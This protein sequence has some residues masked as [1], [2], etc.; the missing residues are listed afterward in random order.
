MKWLTCSPSDISNKP[1]GTVE[2]LA[3]AIDQCKN[4]AT[5]LSA[6]RLGKI[7][8][9]RKTVSHYFPGQ[10][11]C[12]S[13]TPNRQAGRNTHTRAMGSKAVLR[14]TVQQPT[15][16]T[17]DATRL[18]AVV[19]WHNR[20]TMVSQV[21]SFIGPQLAHKRPDGK[22]KAQWCPVYFFRVQLRTHNRN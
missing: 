17:V 4:G 18:T 15:P 20:S 21:R 8:N 6:Y 3:S 5:L 2:L 14:V 16:G 10:P 1:A 12:T 13:N 7:Q 9:C 19:F 22:C 11:P